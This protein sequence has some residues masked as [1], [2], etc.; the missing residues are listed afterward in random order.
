MAEAIPVNQC[1]TCNAWRPING[2]QAGYCQAHPPAP[3]YGEHFKQPG[4]G[5]PT[6]EY[7]FPITAADDWC[8]EFQMAPGGPPA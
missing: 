3:L 6:L 8:R 7:Y 4:S 2:G 1:S 5:V